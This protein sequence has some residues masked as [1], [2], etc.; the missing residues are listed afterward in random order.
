MTIYSL[1]STKAVLLSDNIDD[2]LE[3][4]MMLFV[5][6]MSE[7]GTKQISRNS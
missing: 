2:H 3:V 1:I 5:Y 6:A 4:Y 7:I